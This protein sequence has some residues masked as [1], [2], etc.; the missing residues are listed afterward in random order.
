GSVRTEGFDPNDFQ[1]NGMHL[2]NTEKQAA[3]FRMPLHRGPHP[4]YNE[5]VA[6]HVARLV[7]LHPKTAAYQLRLLQ[8]QLCASLR[9][10]QLTTT[11]QPRNPFHS[12]V[13]FCRLDLD[14]QTV[15]QIAVID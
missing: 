9:S 12:E 11:L 7:N 5:M 13:D 4:R 3:I 8:I 1:S 2:P 10:R 6:D 14:I 15:C